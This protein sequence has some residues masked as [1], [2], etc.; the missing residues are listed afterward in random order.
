MKKIS[1][2]LLISCISVSWSYA[3]KSKVQTAYNFYK[4]PYQQYD[5]AKEA[6][7][8]AVA[9][10]ATSGMPKAW[11]YR[12][13]I[14]QSLFKSE[15]YK[16]LCNNCLMI[17]YE[18]YQKALQLDPKNEWADEINSLWIPRLSADI[19]ND[20]VAELKAGNYQNAMDRFDASIKIQ[21]SD[22]GAIVNCSIAASKLHNNAKS[23]ELLQKLVDMHYKNEGIYS[24]YAHILKTENKTD[25]ALLIV[26]AARQEFPESLNLII[27]E[28][29]ILLAANRPSEVAGILDAAVKKD[30]T[31]PDLYLALGSTYDNLANPEDAAAKAAL[32]PAQ[33][34]EYMTK[35]E[36]AYRDGL[37]VAPENYILNYNLGVLIFNQ[38]AEMANKANDLKSNDEYAKAKVKFDAKFKEAEPFLEKAMSNNP[39]KDAEDVVTYKST[40]QSLK[41]L[42][43]RTN[44]TQKYDQVKAELEKN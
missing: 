21:P 29:N 15:K 34:A 5:K 23:K 1:L 33:Y 10:E 28:I 35:S 2:L 22:T 30:P 8:E 16:S 26:R 32:K 25:S 9:N 38:G 41:Q 11:Y 27:T 12:G 6:I 14:Y 17:A 37:K 3:Q 18:S 40:L 42:Y 4:E 36:A 39:K 24:E 44:E 43:V 7:D 31:N 20:G 19:Y 13:Q